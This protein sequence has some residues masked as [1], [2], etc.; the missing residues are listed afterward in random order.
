[1]WIPAP[2]PESRT[3]FAG[4]AGNAKLS[5]LL[6]RGFYSNIFYMKGGDTDE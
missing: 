3:G 4:M 6:T 5:Y 2:R 1:M